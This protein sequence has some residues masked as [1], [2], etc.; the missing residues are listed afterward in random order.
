MTKYLLGVD[1][2]NSKTDYMLF[3]ED[4]T[5]VDILRR[6][7]CSHER[8]PT[9]YAGA[10][11]AMESHLDDLFTKNNI[12]ITD[13]AS[14]A[15]GLAGADLPVQ[16]QAL[17]TVIKNLGFTKFAL[18][19]DGIL[20][21]KAV[22]ETGVC[23]ISGTGAVVVGINQAGKM[24]QVG[25]IGQISGDYAGG[26][27][28]TKC[29]VE[30]VYSYYYRMGAFSAIIPEILKLHGTS[31]ITDLLTFVSDHEWRMVNAKE[32]IKIIDDAAIAGD[33]VAAKILDDVGICSAEGVLGCIRNLTFDGEITVVKAGS[34]WHRLNYPGMTG[35][36][37]D[38]IRRNTVQVT[39]FVMLDSPPA[40]GAVFWA[41]ELLY[42][43]V[44]ASYRKEM[45]SYFN[46]EK[47]DSL[48]KGEPQ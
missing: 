36:F 27:H 28:I 31:D 41:M 6:P 8:M 11:E 24:L 5:F 20:G 2:G 30:A 16:I 1:G 7:T 44:D 3:R 19:N 43:Q 38:T 10:Q 21:V 39:R 34:I 46:A 32:I 22:A 48:T 4:G 13:I 12:N 33:K 15:F 29:G 23:A 18:A 35:N 40:L 14:A 17:N 42:G 25:G 45:L 47:Y 9:G 26:G 37:T